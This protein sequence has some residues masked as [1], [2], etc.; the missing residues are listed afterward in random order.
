M[1]A[2]HIGNRITVLTT[3]DSSNNYAMDLVHRRL[4]THGEVIFALEQTAGKG[5]MGRSWVTTSGENI[6][7]SFILETNTLP[8]DSV[9]C[10][11][12]AV[13]L[14]CHDWLRPYGGD[15]LSIKWPNDIYWRDRKAGGIL[16]ENNWSGSHWQFAIVGIGL[17]INQTVFDPA[18]TRAVSLKQITG[19]HFDL[20]EMLNGLCASLEARW[21]ELIS[22]GKETI[23]ADYNH[24][25][26]GRGRQVRLSKDGNS[27]ETTVRHVNASGE[28]LTTDTEERKFRVGEVQWVF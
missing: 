17:N 1:A 22:G 18:T 9:F 26:F 16:I 21:Q 8:A 4:A 6:I 24:F 14:G 5:R 15:E 13:A 27:F 7:A 2:Q 20:M 28:L 25:L 23:L 19:R 12:M 11:S 10:L 3:V